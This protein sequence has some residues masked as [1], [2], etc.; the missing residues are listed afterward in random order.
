MLWNNAEALA[1]LARWAPY[2]FIFLG[3]LLAVGGQFVR[4]KL[5]ERV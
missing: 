3:F 1:K 5:D 2:V 4:S